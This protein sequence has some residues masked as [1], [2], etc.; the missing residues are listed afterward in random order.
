M[1]YVGAWLIWLRECHDLELL[2]EKHD[3]QFPSILYTGVKS[4]TFAD[5]HELS[6]T[7]YLK[8]AD[9]VP[10]RAE[11]LEGSACH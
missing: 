4:E 11:S 1:S 3:R 8:I 5:A 7:R 6:T 2:Y 10:A 9:I